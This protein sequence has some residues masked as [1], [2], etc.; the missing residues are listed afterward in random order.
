MAGEN[1][2]WNTQDLFE[3]IYKGDYPSWTA[4]VQVMTAEQAEK[5]RYN[6]FDL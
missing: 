3:S 6:I 1:P 4:H 5:F 2:D